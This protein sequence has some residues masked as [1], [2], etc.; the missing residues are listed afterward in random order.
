MDQ[1]RHWRDAGKSN[2]IDD[3]TL[4]LPIVPRVV[5]GVQLLGRVSEVLE[6]ATKDAR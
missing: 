5:T 3:W 6:Q 4:S 1:N 2:P